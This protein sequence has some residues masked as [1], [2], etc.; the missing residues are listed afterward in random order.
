MLLKISKFTSLCPK[1][2]P[3]ENTPGRRLLGVFGNKHQNRLRKNFS[4]NK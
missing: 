1:R 3:R 2:L 4:G